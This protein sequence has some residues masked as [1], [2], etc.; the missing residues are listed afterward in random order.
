MIAALVLLA[1]VVVMGFGLRCHCA[2][3]RA[4]YRARLQEG[5]ELMNSLSGG[6]PP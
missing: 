2:R 3:V 6:D 4:E 5:F 1:L